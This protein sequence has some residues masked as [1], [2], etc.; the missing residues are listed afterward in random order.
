MKLVILGPPGAG[1]GTQAEALMKIFGVPH[2][3][4]GD[5]LRDAIKKGTAVGMEAKTYIDDGNLVPDEMILA[6]ICERLAHEDCIKGFI[7]DGAPR[8]IPQAESLEESGIEVDHVLSIEVPDDEIL[9]RLAG[10]RVCTNCRLSYHLTMKPPSVSGIC[11]ACGTVLTTRIDDEP[12]TVK[13]RLQAYHF[14]TEPL[15]EHYRLKGKLQIVRC[16][17]NVEETTAAILE[18]LGIG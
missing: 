1:K 17:S 11:D 13:H 2:I 18:A 7:L 12:E 4:T 10:R 3:S 9:S 14:Q 6:I 5:I 8:T 16:A 15:K